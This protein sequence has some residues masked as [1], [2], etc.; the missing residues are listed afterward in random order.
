MNYSKIDTLLENETCWG[1]WHYN[2][3]I[4]TLDYIDDDGVH[5]YEIDLD[6]MATSAQCL[7]W[8][9]QVAFKVWM[10]DQDRTALLAAIRK[11]VHPQRTLCAW[12]KEVLVAKKAKK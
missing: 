4:N 9:F 2:R 1:H 6:R 12:G 5:C 8:I 7:D 10:N 11:K 3:E